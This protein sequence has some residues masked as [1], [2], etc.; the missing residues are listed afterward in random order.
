MQNKKQ[1]NKLKAQ[2]KQKKEVNVSAQKLNNKRMSLQVDTNEANKEK[3]NTLAKR[4]YH[5]CVDK[6]AEAFEK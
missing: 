2:V 6:L 5:I 1:G 4:Y 3:D